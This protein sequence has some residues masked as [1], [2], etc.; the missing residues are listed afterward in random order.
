MQFAPFLDIS[1]ALRQSDMNARRILGHSFGTSVSNPS[2]VRLSVLP[3]LIPTS[4]KAA[5]ETN[6]Q[7]SQ[8]VSKGKTLHN[9]ILM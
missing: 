4:S 3:S 6:K 7:S 1:S 5:M 9:H 8:L 2:S